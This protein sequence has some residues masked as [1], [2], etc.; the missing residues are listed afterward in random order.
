M[1]AHVTMKKVIRVER[2]IQELSYDIVTFKI[3]M[4]IKNRIYKM[5]NESL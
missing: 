3:K 2:K 5:E 4:E 1:E